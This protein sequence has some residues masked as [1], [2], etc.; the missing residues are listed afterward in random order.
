METLEELWQLKPRKVDWS[1]YRPSS[2]PT[3]APPEEQYLYS[4]D[5]EKI[6]IDIAKR[7]RKLLRAEGKR[8]NQRQ[9][10]FERVEEEHQDRV[11]T[12]RLFFF[13][14]RTGQPF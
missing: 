14:K 8:W 2:L 13:Q 11:E 9:E 5:A 1:K 7:L 4:E 10:Y 12:L 6:L 3:Q